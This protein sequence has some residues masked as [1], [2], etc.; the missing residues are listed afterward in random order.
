MFITAQ[1]WG[2]VVLKQLGPGGS[3]IYSFSEKL[4]KILQNPLDSNQGQ[5][6]FLGSLVLCYTHSAINISVRETV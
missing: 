2:I 6:A 3:D 5:Q 4:D 1:H